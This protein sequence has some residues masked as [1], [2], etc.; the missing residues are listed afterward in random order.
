MAKHPYNVHQAGNLLRS[1]FV[2]RHWEKTF[3][4]DAVRNQAPRLER[5]PQMREAAQLQ[6]ELTEPGIW[7][8]VGGWPPTPG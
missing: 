7:V 4:V 8:I 5:K 1:M 3:D 6:T 2:L